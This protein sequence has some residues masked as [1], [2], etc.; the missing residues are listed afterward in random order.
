[1]KRFLIVFILAMPLGGCLTFQDISN[2]ANVATASVSNPVTK[3]NLKAVEDGATVTFAALGAYKRVCVSRTI[4]QSCRT[5][6]QKLQVYTRK[7][8]PLLVSLRAFIRDNDQ[9][10]AVIVYNT[11]K[12][13]VSDFKSVASSNNVPLGVI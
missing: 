5:V 7:L 10:N 11:I 1:M 2:V 8:P 13:L 3:E 9:I 12:Q 6:I 4:D